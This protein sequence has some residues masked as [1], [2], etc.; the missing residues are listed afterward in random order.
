MSRVAFYHD[1]DG[2]APHPPLPDE[3]TRQ[4]SA[5]CES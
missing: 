2:V 4:S 5:M 1:A 3:K